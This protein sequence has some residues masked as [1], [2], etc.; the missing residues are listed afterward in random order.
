MG[1]LVGCGGDS[2]N[3]TGPD[4]ENNPMLNGITVA[5]NNARAA[6]MPAPPTPM[7]P[8]MW[9]STVAAAAQAWSDNCMFAHGGMGNYGQNI[10]ASAGSTAADAVVADW[11]AEK[12]NYDYASN[13]CSGTCGHYTQVVWAASL[14]LGC[15]VTNCTQNSP[16]QGFPSWQM[17]VCDYD[18][19]GNFNGERPY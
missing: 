1:T 18:P 9:S 19:A 2:S 14:N 8:L 10:Y 12:A 13:T 4:V 6:V 15:G 3:G 11:V 17:W 16:F 7:P 5:H